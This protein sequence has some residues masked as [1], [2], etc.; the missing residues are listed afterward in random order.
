MESERSRPDEAKELQRNLRRFPIRLRDFLSSLIV[1]AA[2]IPGSHSARAQSLSATN[3]TL[4]VSSGGRGEATITAGSPVTLTAS[5]FAGGLPVT[6]GQV[7]FCDAD[8]LYCTDIHLLG[9]AQLTSAG[10]ATFHFTPGVGLHNY[11]AKFYGSGADAP[12]SSNVSPLIV[13]GSIPTT[14]TVAS[15]GN[16]GS[17]T[18]TATASGTGPIPPTGTVSFLDLNN[19]NFVLATVP[20]GG[21]SNALGFAN[22]PSPLTGP[23]PTCIVVGDFNG[24]GESDIAIAN[25]TNSSVTVLL[26]NGDGTFTSAPSPAT[27]GYP[28]SIAVGDFN[29]DGNLDLVTTNGDNSLT[30]L[31]GNGDGTFTAAPSLAAGTRPQFAAVGDFNGDG[32]ADLAVANAGDETV[33]ILLGHGDGTFSAAASPGTGGFPARVMGPRPRRK[34][35]SF[36]TWLFALATNLYRSELRRIPATTVALEDIGEPRA[37]AIRG[38]EE[39]DRDRAVQRAVRGLPPKYR[40][41][42]ILFYFSNQDIPTA[43]RTLGVPEGT[44]KARLSR[45][46]DILRSKLQRLFAKPGAKEVL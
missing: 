16:V 8:A 25:H 28:N 32:N 40:D 26:G 41:A 42:L 43:A 12:S 4:T 5:V 35:A 19:N 18:L 38:V 3:T 6:A 27:G 22:T 31:L 24:D 23:N 36:S 13:T 29:G 1:G 15:S 10:T 9:M 21:G 17:Y 39:D 37:S 30:V 33:S 14:V 44:L 11:R 45:G 34:E 7:G 20:V 46:R 2:F